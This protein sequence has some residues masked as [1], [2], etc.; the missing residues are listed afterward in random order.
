ARRP[1]PHVRSS[2]ADRLAGL[3][4]GAAQRLLLD[5]VSAE[6]ATVLGY[7]DREAVED[8]RSFKELGFDSL[9]AVEL[10]NRLTAATGVPLPATLVF[11]YPSPAAVAGHLRTLADGTPVRPTPP[12]AI[13]AVDAGEPI[14]IVGMACR[15]PGGVR[16]P[17]EFWELLA[18]GTDAIGPFPADRDW[19]LA[20]LL[21][22]GSQTPRSSAARTGGFLYDAGDFD[23]DFFG[24]SPREATAMDPQQ[25]L[26][27]QTA[28]EALEH[29]RVDPTSLVGSQTGVFVGASSSGFGMPAHQAAEELGGHVLTGRT[30]SVLSGRVAYS[31]GLEG[32]AV[33]VDTAC[34]SSLVALHLAGQALRQRECSLALVGGV[35][36]MATPEMF[37]EFTR[38]GGLAPDGRC[39]SFASAADGTGWAEGVGVLLLQRLSDA[40]RDGRRVLAVVRGSA[41]NQ[42]GA[43]NGLTAPNGPAQQRVIRR[44]LANAGLAASEVEAVE[45]HGTGTRLGDPIEAQALLAT[46]GQDRPSDRPLR[47]GSVKSNIGHAQA[48]AGVAGV[49]KM[50]LAMRHEVLPATLHIDE[51]SPQV[52]WD[53]GAVSLLT[54]PMAWPEGDHPRRA[55]VSSFGISGTNAHVILEQA[56]P[57]PVAAP[58]AAAVVPWVLSAKTAAGLDEQAAR[59]AASVDTRPGLGVADVGFSLATTRAGLVHRAVLL[60][61]D[62]DE[63]MTGLGALAARQPAANV[64]SGPAPAGG[65]RVAFVFPGQGGQWTGMAAEL[66]E[67]SPQF[68]R[69]LGDCADAL[70]PFIS[71][72]LL[73]VIRAVP[74]APALDRV[75]VVQPAL[76]AVMVSLARLWQ[77][78]GVEPAAVVGHS[79]GEVAAAH[80]AGALDLGDAAR[81]VALRSRILPVLA[82]LGA[83][84]SVALDERRVREAAA[85]FGDRLT[86]AAVNGPSSV[87][88]SGEPAA[89]A[90]LAAELT[91]QGVRVRD[92]PVNYASHSAQIETVRAELLAALAPI[93]PRSAQVPFYSTV[94]GQQLDTTGLDAGYWYRNLRQ[95]VRFEAATRALLDSGTDVFIEVSPHPVLSAA[96]QETADGARTTTENVAVVS[97]LRRDDAGLRRF[98]AAL[99]ETYVRGVPVDW[100]PAFADLP[101]NEVDLPTYP[102]Q[103]R[104]FW[105]A[106]PPSSGPA[107]TQQT[108][109]QSRFWEMVG[110]ADLDGLTATLDLADGVP[111]SSLATVLPVLS[112]WHRRQQE[113]AR[114][115]R[116]RYRTT[117]RPLPDQSP[118][119][120]AGRW[121]VVLPAGRA[122]TVVIDDCLAALEEQGADVVRLPVSAGDPGEAVRSALADESTPDGVISLLGCAG[123]AS[124]SDAVAGTLA[125]LQ[126]LGGA[127]VP[128]PLW[129]LSRGAVTTGAEAV[130]ADPSQAA[131]WGLGFVAALEHPQQWGGL[132]DLP[133]RLDP[134]ARRRLCAVLS[135]GTGED[136]VA[137]R[138]EGI[139]A[140][141]LIRVPVTADPAPDWQ[142]KGTALVVGADGPLLIPAARWLAGSGVE[143]IVLATPDGADTV[144]AAELAADCGRAGVALRCVTCDI[145]DR[146]ALASL[147]RSQHPIEV[148]VHPTASPIEEPLDSL[149]GARIGP[150]LAAQISIPWAL[151]ELSLDLS[152]SR[153]LLFT[154]VAGIWGTPGM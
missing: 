122:V 89:L 108:D 20:E 93:R 119:H 101:V 65:R 1:R 87:V 141:R 54:A 148:L 4:D 73:D 64:V 113:Q 114:L 95:E 137:V 147:V 71:W 92:I 115:D 47:L 23:P 5:I 42:D 146:E 111:Q 43:S 7:P 84:V 83:M 128:V 25:R 86:V 39:K 144:G 63:A 103:R 150:L 3:P 19:D 8:G 75:D 53:S 153:F 139:F 78:Y 110:G 102:F 88:L 80:I 15:F 74:G 120:L 109:A 32:P 123:D 50:V 76:F 132:V 104:R 100:R 52:D 107:V 14:A 17:E 69:A 2:L 21:A 61:G 154:G 112:A 62:R 105:S 13:T 94:T 10:R 117:W 118:G 22:P 116:W 57:R 135:G 106:A 48:A 37:V 11:D 59:L 40:V 58:C 79:Q 18:N 136:Q 41:V 45:A 121:L 6:A 82:G 34:S 99:A 129:V 29:G 125:L 31:L 77:S 70:A 97:S 127:G 66:L 134:D 149:D 33:T 138:P 28:W 81:V 36:I 55:G 145:T 60:V 51:P 130:V 143:Q 85:R 16:S 56:P 35:T 26:L 67:E 133:V 98:L 140:R 30:G 91:A 27:L 131:L 9:T 72:S 126:V 38:Q 12:G 49:I 44:A 151:H 96:I 142:P 124:V 46:Y 68:A 152:L 90:E 24:I